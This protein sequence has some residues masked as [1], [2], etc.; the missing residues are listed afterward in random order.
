VLAV[1]CL[2]PFV[3]LGVGAAIGATIGGT[4]YAYWGCAGGFAVGVI[5]VLLALNWLGHIRGGPP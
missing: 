2:I 1:G 4:A 5:A 3:L